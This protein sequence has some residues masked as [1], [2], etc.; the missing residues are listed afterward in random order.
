MD[1]KLPSSN[2]EKYMDLDNF[3][4]LT[5]KDTVKFVAGNIEDLE[6][7]REIIEKYSLVGKC[8]VY[9]SPVFGKIE[10]SSIV[11]F[12][13]KYKIEWSKYATSNAQNNM[14]SRSKRGVKMDIEA[15]KHH[16]KGLLIALG[17]DP[18][19]EGLKGNSN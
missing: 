1:Y 6:K 4:Y 12:M 5:E 17:D 9:I 8:A 7:A 13:K 2:M 19:R 18:E 3:Q 14:G 11:E 10:L 16:I 15:I